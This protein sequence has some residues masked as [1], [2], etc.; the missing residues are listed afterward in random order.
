M[1]NQTTLDRIKRSSELPK[2]PQ[3]MLKLIKACDNDRVETAEITN[4]ITMD[5]SLTARLL[6]ILGSA[7]VNLRKEIKT[8]DSAVVYLGINT[9][10]NIAISTSVIQ[11]FDD[12]EKLNGFNLNEFWHHSFTCGVMS[13]LI[14]RK[15]GMANPDEAFL[16]GLL[17]DIG[18][19]ILIRNFPEEYAPILRK[20]RT[21]QDK[22]N[23]ERDIFNI[24]SNEVGAWLFRE[25]KLNP[26]LS[27][28]VLYIHETQDRIMDALP[29]V[30]IIYAANK[31]SATTSPVTGS[32]MSAL[33]GVDL[34]DLEAI[35]NET[36]KKVSEMAATLGIT[37]PVIEDETHSEV[38]EKIH[39]DSL[40]A[41]VKDASLLYGTL[42]NLLSA[43]TRDS[44]L[45]EAG[46]GI[47]ALLGTKRVFFF[48]CDT[49]DGL[50]NGYCSKKDRQSRIINNIAIPLNN[51]TSLLIKSLL[52]KKIINSLSPDNT[53]LQAISDEQ[54]I[55]LLDTEGMYCLPLYTQDSLIGVMT[56]GV[57]K[58]DIPDLIERD[59]LIRLF[60]RQVSLCLS[61]IDLK[62]KQGAA[63][64]QE[65]LRAYSTITQKIIHEVNNP[66]GII[67]NYLKC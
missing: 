63:L 21:G 48:L 24:T 56:L 6:E 10:K 36:D 65:K 57:M 67:I 1:L 2:L 62:K 47:R 50:L 51:R 20:A 43:S 17:H 55:R 19:L 28:A 53:E 14:A 44:I 45:E 15:T 66:M 12:T 23:F 54:I 32:D 42:E 27:D 26:L 18:K 4:I 34:S 29:I 31:L 13:E 59:N 9:I 38:T 40:K 5:P 49:E 8:I 3:V 33:S 46:G 16:A 64:Q 25:W 7:Y 39:K 30:R 22:L 52:D 60:I 41:K 61:N 37:L 58:N 35:I 11:V